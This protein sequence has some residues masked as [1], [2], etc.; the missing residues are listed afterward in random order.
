MRVPL[1]AARMIAAKD[2]VIETSS[3]WLCI[4]GVEAIAKSN[5]FA[6]CYGKGLVMTE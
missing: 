4:G 2:C 1:P 3:T 5:S 6:F